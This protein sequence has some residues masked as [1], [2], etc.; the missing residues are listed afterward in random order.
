MIAVPQGVLPIEWLRVLEQ[1]TEPTQF[2]DLLIHA[3]RYLGQGSSDRVPLSREAETLKN[4]LFVY[5]EPAEREATLYDLA[6]LSLA[7]RDA[8]PLVASGVLGLGSLVLAAVA[9]ARRKR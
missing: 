2:Q 6:V 7:R 8:Q 5:F 1:R 4:L 9:I 3:Q